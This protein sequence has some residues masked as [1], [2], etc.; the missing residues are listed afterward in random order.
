[1]LNPL[2]LWFLPLAALPVILHLLNLSRVREVALPT[3]RFL[4]EGYVQ[5][6]RRLKLLEWLLL[7][8]RT[9]LVALAVTAL[10]RPVVERAGTLFGGGGGRD[11]VFVVDAGMTTG[12]VT[13]GLSALHRIRAATSAAVERLAPDDFV[14][15]VRAGIEPRVLHRGARGDGQ[16]IVAELDRL[17]PDPG[18]ADLAGALAEAIAG[19]P[20][21]PRTVWVVSNCEA[22]AWQRLGER[23]AATRLPDDVRLVVADL[24]AGADRPTPN[25]AVLGDPPRAQRPVVG[26]PVELS[27][28]VAAA[29]FDRAADAKA[30][31][32]LDDEVVAQVPLVVPQNG[33]AT[34]TVPLVPR[35]PGVLRGRVALAGDAFPEDDTLHF[36]LN[37]EPRVGVLVV[38]PPD[39]E[40]LADPALFLRTALE[41][42]R[43]L[44]AGAAADT[45]PEATPAAAGGLDVAVARADALREEQVRAADVIVVVDATLDGRRAAWIRDRV[46]AG[47]AGLMLLAGSQRR[48]GNAAAAVFGSGA[49]I[50]FGAPV[51]DL[52]AESA[53]RSPGTVDHSHPVLASFAPA[54]DPTAAERGAMLDTL[55][56]FRHAPLLLKPQRGGPAT[57]VLVRLDDGTPLV[58]ET[59][60]GKGRALVCGLPAT[61]DWSNLPVH[62]AFVP[63]VLRAVQHLRPDPPVVAVE[64]VR[65]CEPA[66]V[67][68][69]VAW[70]R[71]VVQVADPTG[72]SSAL[73]L[74]A[75][76]GGAAAA[77]DDTCRIG[78]YLFDVEPPADLRA[79]PIRLGMAVNAD[80]ETA[81]LAHMPAADIARLFAPHAV[82][83]L[84]GTAEDPTLHATLAGR[85]E[86]W[87]S[88]ILAVFGLFALEFVLGTLNPAAPAGAGRQGVPWTARLEARLARAVGS[89]TGPEAA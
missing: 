83:T 30:T 63:L 80:V 22:R 49:G 3:Y 89:D 51:G 60:L 59:R 74:V 46:S 5:Q 32:M 37:V 28:R 69:D 19:P 47:N 78:T 9:A 65:A 16:R 79:A 61:P 26:L 50:G 52:D 18:T 38:A 35:R 87:R 11:V 56:V 29:G 86:I 23:P 81:A 15:I 70:R 1:M 8:L 34:A 82:T 73:E 12:L 76:D 39:V 27:V 72:R 53:A 88:L 33:V 40:P 62:P 13:D 6:R 45:A 24:G 67:R 43:S 10:A 68:L 57:N 58:A 75:G 20:R 21:G 42:P 64:S 71:A 44:A 77:L 55:V 54:A 84:A 31:V 14:T 85:R 36:V 41:S 7:A 2:L 66:P 48:A 17:E 4:M 25:L